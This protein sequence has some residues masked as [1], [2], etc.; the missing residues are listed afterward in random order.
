M[1]YNH[2]TMKIEVVRWWHLNNEAVVGSHSAKCILIG[3]NDCGIVVWVMEH[4]RVIISVRNMW[5]LWS[6]RDVE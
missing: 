3:G 6:C 2:L 5:P 4:L 1:T